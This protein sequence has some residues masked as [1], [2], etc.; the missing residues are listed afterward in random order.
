[1][2]SST[3]ILVPSNSPERIERCFQCL[4]V[5]TVPFDRVVLVVWGESSHQKQEVVTRARGAIKNFEV[6]GS[7]SDI[8]PETNLN[9]GLA[10]LSYFPPGYVAIIND[11]TFLHERWNETVQEAAQCHGTNMA[12]ATVVFFQNCPGLVQSAGHILKD[13]RPHDQQYKVAI[14]QLSNR[15]KPLC[16]CGNAAFVPWEL[17]EKIWEKDGEVWDAK[18]ERWQSC[19]DFGLKMWLCGFGCSLIP[20]AQALHNGYLDNILAGRRITDEDVKKQLRSR[21][22]L[23]SKFYPLEER[24]QAMGLLRASV[25]RWAQR[26]YPGAA[27]DI[28]GDR[29]RS[30][31]DIAKNEFL[32]LR[33]MVNPVWLDLMGRLDGQTRRSLL[34]GSP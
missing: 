8:R 13:A 18:F 15:S 11:D 33:E 28:K 24:S 34:F 21:L 1:M 31:Y 29:I 27:D 12:Y 22:L 19:F 4:S 6:V 16:P 26:G 23:Y 30:I 32:R 17:I 3:A 9:L 5:Q 10:H 14:E 20:S 25:E 7:G 2:M